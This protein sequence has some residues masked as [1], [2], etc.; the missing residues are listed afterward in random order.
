MGECT[1]DKD[2][3]DFSSWNLTRGSVS[4]QEDRLLLVLP[5]SKTDPFRRGVTLT[6]SAARDEAF[7]VKSLRNLLERFPKS[8]YHPLFSTSAGTFNRTYV[9]RKLHEGIIQVIRLEEEPQHPQ[10]WLDYRRKRYNCLVDG[11]QTP[12][13]CILTPP[14]IGYITRLADIREHNLSHQEYP[15][16]PAHHLPPRFRPYQIIL[17]PTTKSTLVDNVYLRVLGFGSEARY[18]RRQGRGLGI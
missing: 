4:L 16:L 10:D 9:T 17:N 1:Y 13:G 14:P 3:H 15:L 12:T 5:S 7:A 11:S 8:H 2:E 18:V 6:I